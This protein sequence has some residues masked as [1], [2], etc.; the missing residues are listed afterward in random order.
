MVI[1][2]N[3]TRWNS[4][5]NSIKRGLKLKSRI[6]LFCITHKDEIGKD[7]LADDDWRQLE[8][9]ALALQPFCTATLRVEGQAGQGHH[10]SV[11]EVLP[12]LEYLLGHQERAI[13]KLK[14]QGKS[15]SPLAVAHQNAWEKLT[16]YYNKTDDCHLIYAAAT[17]LNPK[18]RKAFFDRHWKTEE[19]EK[20][21]DK[22]MSKIRQEWESSYR[23]NL[24]TDFDATKLQHQRDELDEFLD[25]RE[26]VD[27]DEFTCY[28]EGAPTDLASTDHNLLQWWMENELYPQ[29][30]QLAFDTLSIP[31]MSAE[32]ERIFSSAKKLLTPERNQMSDETIEVNELLRYWW[33]RD[34]IQQVR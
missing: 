32:I 21:K 3:S 4:T 29:L 25:P 1:L 26:D 12:I 18:H 9:I 16:K 14:T 19:S 10:G 5:Y 30:R 8:E 20:W 31:A 15:K 24:T 34:L 33:S 2:D 6:Q 28:T 11:W 23:G 7:F 17:L 27:G 13:Q 22:M